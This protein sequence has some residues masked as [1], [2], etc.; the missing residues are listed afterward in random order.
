MNWLTILIA[1]ILLMGVMQLNDEA[2][3]C[4]VPITAEVAK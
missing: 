3:S 2:R 1:A 4:H